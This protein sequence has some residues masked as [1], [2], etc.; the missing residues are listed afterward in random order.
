MSAGDPEYNEVDG[1]SRSGIDLPNRRR[2]HGDM[3][4][5][6]CRRGLISKYFTT[7]RFLLGSFQEDAAGAL[8]V[9]KRT[10]RQRSMGSHTLLDEVFVTGVACYRSE[11]SLVHCLEG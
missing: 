4:S 5:G 9:P 7:R 10:N 11:K 3:N 8:I 2:L 6:S 1:A